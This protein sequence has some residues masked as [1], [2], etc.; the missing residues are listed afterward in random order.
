MQDEVSD[1]QMAE[2]FGTA[3]SCSR[4]CRLKAVC[5]DKYRELKEEENR[6]QYRKAQFIDGMDAGSGHVA[7]DFI[8]ADNRDETE[9]DAAEVAAAIERLDVS[10]RCRRELLAAFRR[11]EAGKTAEAAALEL[12]RRLGE[13]YV[14]DPTG[15]EVMFFQILAD[16]N[17]AELARRRGCSKQNINKLTA[18]G[19]KRL[20]AYR[21]MVV[22]HPECRLSPRELVVFR[23]VELDGLTYR[24]AADIIG[25]CPM[26][27]HYIVQKMR[28]K[29]VKLYKK[30][31]GRR[32]ATQNATRKRNMGGLSFRSQGRGEASSCS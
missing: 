11:R 19:K 30:C 23:A 7:V 24:Q 4:N 2:C 17:Q 27:I 5:L 3:P 31:P 25:C 1:A 29:G 16:G 9:P 14:S 18:K 12:L 10:E 13:I 15:F 26:T 28:L 32:K 21:Q 8:A 22:A 6:R 20:E